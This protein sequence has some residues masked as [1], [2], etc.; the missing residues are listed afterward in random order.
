MRVVFRT[1][2]ARYQMLNMPILSFSQVYTVDYSKKN[3]TDVPLFI[4]VSYDKVAQAVGI[5]YGRN[6]RSS[7]KNL[8]NK[9]K[10]TAEDEAAGVDEEGS[11][12]DVN[13]KKTVAAE[14]KATGKKAAP[15]KKGVGATKAP[16]K[17]SAGGPKTA[18]KIKQQLSMFTFPCLEF[19][20][21]VFAR[22]P[23][24]ISTHPQLDRSSWTK[25]ILALIQRPR[26]SRLMSM[27]LLT[28]RMM[29]TSLVRR[30]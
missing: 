12:A 21:S 1:S 18:K 10:A 11:D 2:C 4:Q 27:R 25:L 9:M 24:Q 22:L 17:A 5:K 8:F 20:I 14:K 29:G 16:V 23:K 19:W 7:F 30:N 15:A 26:S 3:H 6:A 28:M 13:E